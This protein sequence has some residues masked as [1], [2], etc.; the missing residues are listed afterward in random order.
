MNDVISAGSPSK[1]MA[2]V[3]VVDPDSEGQR[4]DVFLVANLT[5]YSRAFLQKLI[6]EQYVLVDGRSMK[7]SFRVRAGQ[8]VEVFEPPPISADPIPQKISLEI[9]YED[10]DVLVVNKPAGLVVHPAPGTPDGTLVN[11]LLHYCDDLS[12]IGG[13]LRPGIVHRLDRDTSGVLVVSKNDKAHNALSRQFLTH[14]VEKSYIAFVGKRPSAKDIPEQG[15]FDTLFGRH[16]VHRKRYYSKVERGKQAITNFQILRRF[17]TKDWMA[18]KMHLEPK[19]GRTHQ[20][21]VHMADADHP[22]LG[23]KLYGGRSGRCFPLTIVPVRQ[24]LHAQRLAFQHPTTS[25]RVCFESD[26]PEDLKKLEQALEG[27]TSSE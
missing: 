11:A 14:R 13:I 20:L 8:R 26:L 6:D 25:Q 3:I 18:L 27:L 5:T 15:T 22:I 7:A 24:A 9:L 21:R 23:D 2:R 16:P 17:V 19:T 1:A 4:L 10:K 12:G